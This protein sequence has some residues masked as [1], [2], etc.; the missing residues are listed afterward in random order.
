MNIHDEAVEQALFEYN[1]NNKWHNSIKAELK[2][3]SITH[4]SNRSDLTSQHFI[5]IDGSDAKDFE[6]AVIGKK[7][8]NQW[9]LEVAIA[10]VARIVKTGSKSDDEARQR[11]TSIYFPAKVIPML[12]EEISN[13]LC[14][15]VP[16]NVRNVLICRIIFNNQVDIKSYNFFEALI[17]SHLRA[18]YESVEEILSTKVLV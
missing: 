6:D 10:D 8:N 16:N 5:T 11:G 9:V 4:D 18:T 15:L 2:S 13:N 14:S 17:K 1:L 12:P 7:N 3:I